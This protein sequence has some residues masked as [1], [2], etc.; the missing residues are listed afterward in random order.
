[1]RFGA[2][3]SQPPAMVPRLHSRLDMRG[4]PVQ[5]RNW[6]ATVPPDGDPLAND[7]YGCCVPA[8]DFQLAR[9]WGGKVDRSLVLNRYRLIT[10]FDP[11][12]G[13]PDNGTDTATDMRQW[14]AAPI[15]DLDG[16]PWPIYW[17][18][19]DQ[20]DEGAIRLALRRF[21]LR[22]V[23]GLPAAVAQD[24][25]RWA[26]PPEPGWTKDE[27][28][29]VVLGNVWAGGWQVRSWGSDYTV[30]FDLMRLMLMAVDVPIPHP[31]A[32]PPQ[33]EWAGLDLAALDADLASLSAAA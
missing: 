1:M 27:P 25:D 14:I 28:H 15:L 22:I 8:A 23:I 9:I 7:D 12:T 17:A 33:M 16:K 19:V 31:S 26:R 2:I 3:H 18:T 4:A 29:C 32:A 5:P 20:T 6:F 21:P 30:N 10:G 13:Q 24:P 11:A